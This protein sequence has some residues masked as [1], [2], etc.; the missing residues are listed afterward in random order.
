MNMFLEIFLERKKWLELGMAVLLLGSIYVLSGKGA[1]LAAAQQNESKVVV[2]DP[3]HGGRDP[4]KV[5]VNQALEK[6]INLSVAEKV[7]EEMEAAGITVIMTRGEDKG[8]YDEDADNKQVQ[9]LQRRCELIHQAAPD[10]AVSIHQNS[11]SDESV[12]GAQIFYYEDSQEGKNLAACLQEAMSTELPEG[13]MREAK[14]NDSYYLLKKT[15]APAVIVECGFLS[16]PE[17]ADL[18]TDDTYQASLAGAICRGVER[19]LEL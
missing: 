19:Y 1:E 16:N 4:G 11:Y 14:G 17:E 9:D 15:D 8:L 5:G 6:D 3:G 18:L 2:L 10:C 13:T 7:K 12:S